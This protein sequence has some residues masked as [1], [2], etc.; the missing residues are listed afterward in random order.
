LPTRVP[1]IVT[2]TG[3]YDRHPDRGVVWLTEDSVKIN[4]VDAMIPTAMCLIGIT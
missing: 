4:S 2:T 1:L 3:S